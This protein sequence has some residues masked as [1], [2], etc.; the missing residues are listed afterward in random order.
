MKVQ[1][2]IEDLEFCKGTFDYTISPDD[3]TKLVD[4]I[5]Q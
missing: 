3:I 2:I 1:E 4:C 5:K